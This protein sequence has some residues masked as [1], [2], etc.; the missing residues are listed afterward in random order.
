[1]ISTDFGKT[2][3][4][5]ML[6]S[7]NYKYNLFIDSLYEFLSLM[8]IQSEEFRKKLFKFRK[9]VEKIG[10]NIHFSVFVLLLF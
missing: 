2:C 10:M 1:M 8:T 4:I 7:G 6:M 9:F 3:F 5:F